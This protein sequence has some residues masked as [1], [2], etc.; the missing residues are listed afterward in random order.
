MPDLRN[1]LPSRLPRY[2][3]GLEQV[4]AR[5]FVAHPFGQPRPAHRLPAH[6]ALTTRTY[7]VFVTVDRL[8]H[9]LLPARR[10]SASEMRSPSYRG[11]I[12][13]VHAADNKVM[14]SPNNE[15]NVNI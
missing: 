3:P 1:D 11:N 5:Q 2:L 4:A 8:P 15:M 12:L 14:V 10:S 7:N 6:E 9:H 13:P